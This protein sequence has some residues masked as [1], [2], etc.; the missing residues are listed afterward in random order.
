MHRSIKPLN[1]PVTF[2]A[3]MLFA[4][5][6]VLMTYFGVNALSSLHAYS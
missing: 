5:L 3:Y 2:H 1:R 6:A 4:F